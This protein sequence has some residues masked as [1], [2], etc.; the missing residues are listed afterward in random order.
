MLLVAGMGTRVLPGVVLWVLP[1]IVLEAAFAGTC[2][3]RVSFGLAMIN[4]SVFKLFVVSGLLV[5]AAPAARAFLSC[6][7]VIVQEVACGVA[8][9]LWLFGDK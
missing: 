9:F 5:F 1:E 8:V 4:S 7:W 2:V 6:D 3:I